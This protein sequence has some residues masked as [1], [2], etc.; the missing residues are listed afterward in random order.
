MDIYQSHAKWTFA[1]WTFTKKLNI[2]ENGLL[3]R[4]DMYFLR[5]KKV[6]PGPRIP[7]VWHP[8]SEP[9]I[10]RRDDQLD[11]MFFGHFKYAARHFMTSK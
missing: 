10:L 11:T 1:K 5:L 3:P 7:N 9:Y 4:Q 8:L 6:I 2:Q